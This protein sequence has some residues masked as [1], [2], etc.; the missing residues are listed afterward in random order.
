[1][2]DSIE[3]NFEQIQMVTIPAT[4]NNTHYYNFS[5]LASYL[6][7]CVLLS[8]LHMYN[9]KQTTVCGNVVGL[10]AKPAVFTLFYFLADKTSLHGFI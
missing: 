10:S 2:E 7:S 5:F 8:L 3:C 1:M 4:G 6:S 9:I